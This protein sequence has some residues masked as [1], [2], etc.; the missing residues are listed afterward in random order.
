METR[1]TTDMFLSISIWHR[2][3]EIFLTSVLTF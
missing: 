2:F 3:S 1:K